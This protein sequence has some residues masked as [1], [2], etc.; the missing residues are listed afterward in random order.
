MAPSRLKSPEILT[1]P[2]EH[3]KIMTILL[4]FVKILTRSGLPPTPCRNMAQKTTWTIIPAKP[5]MDQGCLGTFALTRGIS[6]DYHLII[7]VKSVI[8]RK[9]A[10]KRLLGGAPSPLAPPRI[11][12]VTTKRQEA[13]GRVWLF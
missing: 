13:R 5:E 3:V 10:H 8:L 11:R 7:S 12:L 1:R 2:L 9:M 6:M 4:N